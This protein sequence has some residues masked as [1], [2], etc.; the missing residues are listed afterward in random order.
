VHQTG[1][2][3]RSER[4]AD[5]EAAA[6]A[7]LAPLR[8]EFP[9]APRF[10][11]HPPGTAAA[12]ALQHF[13]DEGPREPGA[14]VFV[15]GNPTWSFAFRRAIAELR[16]ERR[17]VA[18]DHLGC[19]LSDKPARLAYRLETHVEDLERLLLAL[20][21]LRVT[22][23]LH[24]WGG[25]IGLGFARRHPERIERLVLCNTA[26][27]PLEGRLPL[28]LAACRWPLF[29]K[30]AVRGLNAFAR[31]ATWM[32]VAK[33]LAPLA[34]RGYLLPYDSWENRIATHAFVQDIPLGPEHPSWGELAAIERAL[35]RFRE[36]PVRFLWGLHDWVF[37]PRILA[38]WQ[39]RLPRA[40]V[41]RFE[42]AGHYLFEDE[43]AGFVAGIRHALGS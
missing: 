9:F 31:G 14:L 13:V 5:R 2:I 28:R 18:V 11:E 42:R 41:E 19:G 35:P 32:A 24:D 20:G 36:L 8:S 22:L 38:E 1:T 10:F 40:A 37:T 34:K 7:R 15:H 27:F 21:L 16:A 29:G 6:R 3:L 4:L 39:Q 30:L 12:G 17:C 25:P 43:P 23:V 26:A 33:P